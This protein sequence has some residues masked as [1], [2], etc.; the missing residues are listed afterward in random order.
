M[1]QPP[2]AKRY[3]LACGAISAASIFIILW[4]VGQK[5]P[6][7]L[8][9]RAGLSSFAIDVFALKLLAFLVIPYPLFGFVGG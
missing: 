1:R 2:R 5:T 9:P 7:P 3:G 4:T 6:H 8:T